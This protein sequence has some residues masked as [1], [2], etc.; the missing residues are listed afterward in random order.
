MLSVESSG[1]AYALQ[2]HSFVTAQA[3]THLVV[4]IRMS[5]QV[6][7]HANENFETD[8][9][10]FPASCFFCC[11]TEQVNHD[12]GAAERDV[13]TIKCQGKRPAMPTPMDKYAK[14]TKGGTTEKVSVV[15][16]ATT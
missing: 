3:T 8:L 15:V 11:R 9:H 2:N 14:W 16:H 5:G 4:V 12:Y 10:L 6:L 13:K 1:L 7:L